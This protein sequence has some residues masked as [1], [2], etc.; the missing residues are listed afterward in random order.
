M[1]KAKDFM[2]SYSMTSKNWFE[3]GIKAASQINT[4]KVFANE[5]VSYPKVSLQEVQ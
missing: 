1:A 5:V 2:L 4:N 3:A